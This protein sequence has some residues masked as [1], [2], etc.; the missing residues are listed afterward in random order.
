M[1]IVSILGIINIT[2]VKGLKKKG[3]IGLQRCKPLIE[4]TGVANA[5]R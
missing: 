1:K 3:F 4:S 5:K 2:K